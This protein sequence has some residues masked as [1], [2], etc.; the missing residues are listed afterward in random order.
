[1]TRPKSKPKS[2]A[3]DPDDPD[4]ALVEQW[5]ADEEETEDDYE[6]VETRLGP[7][8]VRAISRDELHKM[9]KADG[10]LAGQEAKALALAVVRP[11]MTSKQWAIALRKRKNADLTQVIDKIQEMAGLQED[12]TKMARA[13]FRD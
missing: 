6:I 11:K 5:L 2:D 1:M 8:T 4:A 13:M 10:G 12:A 3:P 9:V 7:V